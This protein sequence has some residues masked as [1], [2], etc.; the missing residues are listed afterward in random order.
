[1]QPLATAYQNCACHNGDPL[2]Q[3]RLHILRKNDPNSELKLFWGLSSTHSTTDRWSFLRDLGFD[4]FWMSGAMSGSSFGLSEPSVL[5]WTAAPNAGAAATSPRFA[6]ASNPAPL[7]VMALASLR[8]CRIAGPRITTRTAAMKGHA[9]LSTSFDAV[10]PSHLRAP[11][12]AS[13]LNDTRIALSTGA[14]TLR[15]ALQC[16]RD[17]MA[18]PIAPYLPPGSPVRVAATAASYLPVGGAKMTSSPSIAQPLSA[19]DCKV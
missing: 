16:R 4:V 12:R 6:L 9:K 10:I 14:L 5:C 11:A 13:P 17:F 2:R 8:N 15:W 7:K 1:M 3:G 18:V 19:A